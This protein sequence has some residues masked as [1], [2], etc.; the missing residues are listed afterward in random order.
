MLGSVQLTAIAKVSS[1]D[2]RRL[3]AISGGGGGGGGG[4]SSGTPVAQAEIKEAVVTET[5]YGC[6]GGHSQPCY[7]LNV[8][9]PCVN[10]D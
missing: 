2:K 6:G 7:R 4:G 8:P 1:K 10:T 5:C 3:D 9:H